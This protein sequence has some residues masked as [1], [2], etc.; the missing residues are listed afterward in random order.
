[1]GSPSDG[2]YTL[3]VKNTSHIKSCFIEVFECSRNALSVMRVFVECAFGKT[4]DGRGN[5]TA[6]NGYCSVLFS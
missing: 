4:F 6:R 2:V 3:N 5:G 1:M